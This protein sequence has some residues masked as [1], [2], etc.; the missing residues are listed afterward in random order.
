M[1]RRPG[2]ADY[3]EKTDDP[4]IRERHA[5][6]GVPEG[7]SDAIGW[8]NPAAPG[9]PARWEVTFTVPDADVAVAAATAAGGTVE[10]PALDLGM[11]R[12]AVLV[13]PWGA[14]FTVSYFRAA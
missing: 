8:V 4:G 11:V 2:Y 5:N 13:D 12:E 7:F 9:T 3:L 1:L 14:R 10:M 6:P